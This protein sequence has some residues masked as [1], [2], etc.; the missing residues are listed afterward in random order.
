MNRTDRIL[1]TR[2][3]ASNTAP[4]VGISP[5]ARPQVRRVTHTRHTHTHRTPSALDTHTLDVWP[6]N[7]ALLSTGISTIQITSLPLGGAAR[8][9]WIHFV[10][11]Q[12]RTP[13]ASKGTSMRAMPQRYGA[14]QRYTEERGHRHS[15][16]YVR[17]ADTVRVRGCRASGE[18]AR[19]RGD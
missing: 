12:R 1:H 4:S 11:T 2:T 9:A 19:A 16:S 8:A 3:G 5:P 10:R 18:H 7:E 17:C 14:P 13:R 6:R 15:L